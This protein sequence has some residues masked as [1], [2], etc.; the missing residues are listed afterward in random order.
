MCL[1][2]PID[3]SDFLIC[4]TLAER[5]IRERNLKE[6]GKNK[7][8]RDQIP[9]ELL[10]ESSLPGN[11]RGIDQFAA[12][13]AE[14]DTSSSRDQTPLYEEDST[15]QKVMGQMKRFA[16]KGKGAISSKY[17]S[18][19]V[20]FSRKNKNDDVVELLPPGASSSRGGASGVDILTRSNG[21]S[22]DFGRSRKTTVE[23]PN[24]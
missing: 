12:R 4:L 17:H 13:R 7:N 14:R 16:S 5:R 1:N 15:L 10:R 9:F 23:P 24:F 18:S 20:A 2:D 3:S 19:K 6:V 22:G 11:R 21:S 8:N